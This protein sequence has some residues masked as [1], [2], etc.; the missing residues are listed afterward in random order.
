VQTFNIYCAFPLKSDKQVNVT[1]E[2]IVNR[3]IYTSVCW[4]TFQL[5]C[6]VPASLRRSLYTL[7][8]DTN[9]DNQY[10]TYT[11]HLSDLH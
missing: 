2:A 11:W 6:R 10:L 3:L 7:L 9:I 5:A 8:V 1:I 4:L